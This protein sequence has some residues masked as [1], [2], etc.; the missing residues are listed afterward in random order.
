MYLFNAY[1]PAPGDV[2]PDRPLFDRYVAAMGS[3]TAGV[4]LAALVLS[5]VESDVSAAT[6]VCERFIEDIPADV[7]CSRD[8]FRQGARVVLRNW[9]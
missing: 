1:P 3:E 2:I 7:F 8:D 9:T 5:S 6:A 4:S